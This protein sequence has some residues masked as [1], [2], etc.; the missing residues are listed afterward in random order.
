MKRVTRSA[1]HNQGKP[2]VVAVQKEKK[3]KDWTYTL[4]MSTTLRVHLTFL[5]P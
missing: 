3:G 5:A 1:F 4:D 2:D